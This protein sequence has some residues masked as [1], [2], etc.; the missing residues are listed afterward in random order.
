MSLESMNKFLKSK[1]TTLSL[2][3]VLASPTAAQAQSYT[4]EQIDARKKEALQRV[5]DYQKVIPL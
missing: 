4:K 5:K 2:A 3:L 1:C